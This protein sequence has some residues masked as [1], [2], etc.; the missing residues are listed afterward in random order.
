[1]S[2][3]RI[4]LRILD[5]N[6][7]RLRFFLSIA[8]LWLLLASSN[9]FALTVSDRSGGGFPLVAGQVPATILIDGSDY[10]VVRIVAVCLADDVTRVTGLRPDVSTG[11]PPLPAHLVIVGV[12]GHSAPIDQLIKA[13]KL[14]VKAIA[15]QWESYKIQTIRNPMP[16]VSSALVIAGSDRRGAAY[17]VFDL[18]EAI[19]VSPW[20]WWADVAPRHRAALYIAP[21][22]EM[23]GPPSIKYRGIFINDED[24]SFEPWAANTFEPDAGT[25]GPR[26]YAKVCELLLR[27]KANLLWPAMHPCTKAFNS[28]P[29][30]KVVA[31][32]YAIV[33]GASH[34]EPMLRNNVGE[35]D[36]KARGPWDYIN[37]RPNILKYWDQRL[38]EN[39]GYENVYTIGM[40]GIHDSPM[41]GGG[42]TADKVARLQSVFADQRALIAHDVSPYVEQVPQIFVPYKEVLTL[43]RN[44]LDVPPDVTLVWP[45]DNHGYIRELSNPQEQQ[46]PGGSGIYYHVSYWG[47]PEDYL[48]L[49]TT[50]PALIWEE[51]RKAY[52]NGARNLW[53]LNVGGLKKSAIDMDFFMRM[54]WD[55]N[56]WDENAQPTFLAKWAAQ[57]FGPAHASD[58]AAVLGEYFTLN[59]PSKPEHLVQSQFTDAEKQDRLKRFDQ[60]VAK[61]NALYDQLPA[62]NKDSFYELVVYPVRCSALMNER[63]L[64]PDPAEAQKAYDQIQDQTGY[65]NWGLEG[66]KWAGMMS[67]DPHNQLVFQPP[68]VT[69]TS[70]TSAAATAMAPA[71]EITLTAANPDHESGGK[72]ASWKVIAGLGWSGKSIALWP[73][74]AAV[75]AAKLQ[76]HVSIPKDGS[77]RVSADCIPT[78]ALNPGTQLRYSI[79]FDHEP[80]QTVDIDTAEFSHPW[81]VNVLRA[82]AIGITT[83]TLAAGDHTLTLR[84]LDPGVVFDRILIDPP[85]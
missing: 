48:W 68:S 84:P 74:T 70:G 39:G 67:A 16:G 75:G 77:V 80:P 52:D 30:N 8:A 56:P 79:A 61:T 3:Q 53:V 71:G 26:T 27:L 38:K 5:V 25:V 29:E 73:T 40:R 37:N 85:Q 64:S 6:R 55:I 43:Y 35:W 49:C 57:T 28:D 9:S 22:A 42:T 54:A 62:E 44:G 33:M 31:D 19:G 69:A 12:I 23:H 46:R 50:P 13:G 4:S 47:A 10:T 83:H 17:G 20:V 51:M 41:P 36:V 59:D 18:S 34:A 15:G 78:H 60:L 32:D 45:D 11:A 21:G 65:F 66:A 1:L 81:S 7:A 24:W 2:L 58:I 14:N 82:A 63:W 72:G 76:Y